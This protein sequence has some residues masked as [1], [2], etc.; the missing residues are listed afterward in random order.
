MQLQIG[1]VSFGHLH[2]RLSIRK[3]NLRGLKGCGLSV[4][5]CAGCSSCCAA[6]EVSGTR[7]ACETG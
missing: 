6:T 1:L 5:K 3:L 2:R 4:F 7:A